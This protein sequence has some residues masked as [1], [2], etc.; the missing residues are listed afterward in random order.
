MSATSPAFDAAD[1]H[2]MQRALQLAARGLETTDPNP[3]VGCVLVQGGAIVG[4]S[5]HARAEA[6]RATNA[7]ADAAAHGGVDAHSRLQAEARFK[8]NKV[9]MG[10]AE[11][12][13]RASLEAFARITR[14]R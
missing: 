1:A 14:P 13:E 2:A 9:A 6:I 3:R 11:S 12:T 4:E 8:S 10:H 7:E 5:W